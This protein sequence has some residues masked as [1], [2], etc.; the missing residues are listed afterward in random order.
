MAKGLLD[1]SK[2]KRHLDGWTNLLSGLGVKGRDKRIENDWN[3]SKMTEIDVETLYASDDIS[4]KIIDLLPE[5]ALREWIEIKQMDQDLESDVMAKLDQLGARSRLEEA[6][7][8]ARMYGGSGIYMTIDDGL[9]P[10]YPV[11]EDRIYSIKSL[12]VL[13]RYELIPYQINSNL[14]SPFF[15][16]PE[17]YRLQ[18]SQPTD[19]VA[20]YIHHSR[21]LR[22]DGVLLP[23]RLRIQNQ[24]WGDS[25]FTRTLNAIKNYNSTHDS[26]VSALQDFSVGVFQIRNLADNMA[27]GREDLVKERLELVNYSKSVI[28]S[29]VLDMEEKFEHQ[30]KSLSGVPE[31]M[32]QANSRLVVASGMPHTKILGESP[33]GLGADGSSEERNWYDYVKN[34]QKI[35]L[36]PVLDTLFRYLF[37]SKQGPTGGVTPDKWDYEFVPL[38]QMSETEQA[39]MQLT[40]AQKDLIYLQTQVL[41]PDEVARSRFGGD[42]YSTDTVIDMSMRDSSKIMGYP[43]MPDYAGKPA[44]QAGAPDQSGISKPAVEDPLPVSPA[45]EENPKPA[46][47]TPSPGFVSKVDGEPVRKLQSIITNG[48]VTR[49]R[50]AK[51]MS[52]F[53]AFDG[54]IEGLT[55]VYGNVEQDPTLTVAKN[56][57]KITP[58]A[59]D[60]ED[61][62]EFVQH[63]VNLE[64]IWSWESGKDCGPDGSGCVEPQMP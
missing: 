16:Q 19:F 15:G 33:S 59:P 14:D 54:P 31:V 13:S 12:T 29:I 21:L 52:G 3:Y 44:A 61:P 27:A 47:N 34:Q 38:W 50:D 17:I 41:D 57:N 25:V 36:R 37:L 32:K 51:G 26:A 22:F 9:D 62:D 8:W 18:T 48:K 6:W 63:N 45:E 46:A 56:E 58:P 23:R 64:K 53:K 28:K 24:W 49:V 5:D 42:K 30:S 20:R 39:Q 1:T 4:A 60:T 43:S 2:M 10:Q 55:M 35:V 11:Q 7:K 40:V